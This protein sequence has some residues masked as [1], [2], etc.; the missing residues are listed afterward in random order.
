M[1]RKISDT[2]DGGLSDIF[3]LFCIRYLIFPFFVGLTDSG[4]CY[5]IT[6]KMDILTAMHG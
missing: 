3:R 6:E 1:K 4:F 2:A 5:I